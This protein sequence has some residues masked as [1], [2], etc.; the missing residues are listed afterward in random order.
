MTKQKLNYRD[1]GVNIDAGA[2]LIERIKPLVRATMRAEA[3]TNVGGFGG[4]FAIDTDAYPQ[5]VLV[6]GADGV[7]T[8]L[9]L[10][11]ELDN[12]ATVGIDLVAMCVNDVVAQGAEPL[13]FLDYFAAGQLSLRQ[14]EQVIGGIANGCQTAGCTLLGGE[15]AEMPGMYAAGEY[16][17]AGFCVGVVNRTDI[18][19]ASRV[20]SGDKIIALASSGAHANGYSLIRKIIEQGQ[21]RLQQPFADNGTLGEALMTPTRLYSPSLLA[22]KR[23]L[24]IHALAHITG[25]GLA[26]NLPRVLPPYTMAQIDSGSWQWPPIFDWL[27]QQGN[28]DTD[29]MYRTFNCGVGMCVIV[30]DDNVD[31]ALT[32]LT[33]EGE[34]AWLVGEVCDSAQQQPT[35]HLR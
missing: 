19:D 11:F 29:E 25:G 2:A 34:Q 4:L 5:P 35:V 24:P 32:L 18:I 6:A 15:T 26:E 17:L 8:K 30:A 33:D 21:H 9:K 1:A 28:V 7:G 23:A 12:H 3:L 31:A 22:L 20:H 10:A 16:D 14:A 27:Q 13:F